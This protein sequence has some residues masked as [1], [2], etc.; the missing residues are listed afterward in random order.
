MATPLK[1]GTHSN[2]GY[3]RLSNRDTLVEEGPLC[4]M[5]CVMC[6]KRVGGLSKK[7]MVLVATLGI[8]VAPYT[9]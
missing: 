1:G 3:T 6:I 8:H 9:Y 2:E 5:L 4:P 7:I